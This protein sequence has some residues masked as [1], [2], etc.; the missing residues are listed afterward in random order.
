MSIKRKTMIK[1]RRIV[2]IGVIAIVSGIFLIGGISLSDKGKA[3]AKDLEEVAPEKKE[4]V[5]GG[6]RY[7]PLEE[8]KFADDVEIVSKN[9]NDLIT[10][11]KGFPVRTDG[12]KVAYLTFDDGPSTTVTPEVLKILKE[13][14]VKATFFVLGESVDKNSQSKELIKEIVKGGHAI[15]NHTYTH[16]YK[17]LYPNNI[18]DSEYLISEFE[19]TNQ[20]LS[21][22][23]GT[24]FKSRVVRLPGGY[25]S[26]NGREEGKKALESNEFY[27][28]DWNALNGD[29]EGGKKSEGQLLAKLK[30][31]VD[32]SGDTADNLVL[33]MHDTYGK[34]NTAKTLKESIRY[35]KSK[36]FEF[37]TMK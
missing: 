22:I 12:K 37:K 32:E 3:V 14:D 26:W 28:V 9:L 11:K 2:A 13:E 19:K 10:G 15:G 8:D 29:S 33:L 31:T 17:R 1:R 34:E 35:L 25:W 6:V 27:N 36:G 23:I 16:D 30:K 7:L 5:I 20:S 24:E 18:I 4:E 21:K